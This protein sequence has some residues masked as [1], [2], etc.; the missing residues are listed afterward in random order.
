VGAGLVALWLDEPAQGT[1]IPLAERSAGGQL[2][3]LPAP[4]TAETGAIMPGMDAALALT[5]AEP[6]APGSAG[7]VAVEDGV[8]AA[9]LRLAD[10]VPSAP[11]LL[12]LPEGVIVAE[13]GAALE[14]H[15]GRALKE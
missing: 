2:I 15:E 8:R 4:R 3:P 14:A 11:E 6:A 5:G 10:G 7:T 13:L 12:D 9:R 1:Q